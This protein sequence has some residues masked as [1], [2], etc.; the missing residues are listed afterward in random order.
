MKTSAHA[1]DVNEGKSMSVRAVGEED[2]GAV[3]TRIIPTTR[4]GKTRVT[5]TV[6]WQTWTSSRVFRLS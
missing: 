1:V 4:A 3:F 6:R 2:E 5:E